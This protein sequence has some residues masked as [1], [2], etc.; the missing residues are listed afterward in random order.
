M[1]RAAD[2]TGHG[3]AG[4]GVSLIAVSVFFGIGHATQ[5]LTGI[6]QESLSGALLGLLFLACGR[7]LT[8]PII[9]HGVSN[10]LALVLMYFG[11]YPGLT[12]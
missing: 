8:I 10:T 4:W 5:G 3:A 12:G 9:A 1:N 11:M 2:V 6:V 7:T